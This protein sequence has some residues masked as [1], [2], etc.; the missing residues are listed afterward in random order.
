MYTV[1]ALAALRVALNV[2]NFSADRAFVILSHPCKLVLLRC[3]FCY[4]T[5]YGRSCLHP[6]PLFGVLAVQQLV[7]LTVQIAAYADPKI[8]PCQRMGWDSSTLNFLSMT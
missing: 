6:L 3:L 1:A 4:S 7:K 5:S 8:L 2:Q